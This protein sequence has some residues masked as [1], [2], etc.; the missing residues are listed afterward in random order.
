MPNCFQL[1]NKATKEPVSLIHVDE[2]IC[3]DVYNTEPHPTNWGSNVFNW[4]DSI[5]YQIA[6][7]KTLSQC[8]DYYSNSDIWAD[9]LPT[10]L[11]VISYLDNNFTTKSFYSVKH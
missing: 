6:C 8:K 4:Y 3:K 11:S 7:G 10:I 1:F 5:G 9:E 2:L